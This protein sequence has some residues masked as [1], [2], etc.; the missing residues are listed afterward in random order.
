M[1]D[2]EKMTADN[3]AAACTAERCVVSGKPYCAHPLKGGLQHTQAHDMPAHERLKAAR[4][5]IG[6]DRPP[7]KREPAKE[8]A[9]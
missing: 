4:K 8:A 1:K 3:C 6:M 5:F 7:L 2:F 9:Q